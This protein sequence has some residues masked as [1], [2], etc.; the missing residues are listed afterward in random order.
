MPLSLLFTQP[1]VFFIL[2]IVVLLGIAV[3]EYA[4][5]Y[6]AYKLGDDTAAQLGRLTMNPLA[7][8]DAV[9]LLFLALV[10]FGWG[11]PVPVNESRLTNKRWGPLIVSLSGPL[12]NIIL[13]AAIILFSRLLVSPSDS[14]VWWFLFLMVAI[15]LVLAVFNLIPI[16][17]LDGSS[18]LF[19]LFPLKMQQWEPWLRRNGL[20]LLIALVLLM[21]IA[22]WSPFVK[23]YYL[24]GQLMG[25]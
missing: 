6:S 23:F 4:H 3:H 22:H 11:K 20:W 12:A 7:H 24:A 5:A 2:I 9:G 18:I 25:A 1:L 13:A 17:P 19:A 14:L 10:G 8:I 21:N 15:N 16:P